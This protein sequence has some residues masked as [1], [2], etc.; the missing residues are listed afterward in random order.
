MKILL[1]GRSGQLGWELQRTL[2]SLAEI[3]AFDSR[4]LDIRDFSLLTKTIKEIQPAVI[5]N[6]A[7]FTDVDRAESEPDQAMQVNG[8]A[9]G[10]MAETAHLINAILIHFSTD[11]VFDGRKRTPYMEADTP[12]PINVYGKSKLAGEKA[13]QAVGGAHLIL[14]TSWLYSLRGVNFVTRVL[15]W[16][17]EKET[18]H[19]VDDQVSSPTWARSLAE[20]TARI[21][22]RD[23]DFLNESSGLYH[24]A[25]GGHV[26][27]F[28][29]AK[30]IL[31][32]DPHR[33]EHTVRE[34][35]P[36]LSTDF[37]SL[38]RRPSWSA[39]DCERA[40]TVLGVRLPLWADALRQAM[41]N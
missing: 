9:P 19:I 27:R 39:L 26:S 17:R 7:A 28:E 30:I 16:G 21:L 29:W 40:A 18:L 37:P 2:S 1:L 8:A 36:A 11:Y 25:C 24:L 32:L 3:R 38:A 22:D 35:L 23:M 41:S 15:R 4:E 34:I 5:V 10:V 14:R 13:V 31:E 33:A 12:Q 20:V 6:A